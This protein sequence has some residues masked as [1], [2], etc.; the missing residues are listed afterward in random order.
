MTKICG[1]RV[2]PKDDA[3]LVHGLNT[4]VVYSRFNEKVCAIFQRP[5]DIPTDFKLP[6]NQYANLN[7]T[8][9]EFSRD[10]KFVI[11]TLFRNIY[12][13]QIS[14]GNL[15]TTIQAPVGIVKELLVSQKRSQI[16]THIKGARD[17][18]VW[19]IDEAV[20]QVNMLDRL[21]GPITSVLVTADSSM[22][23]IKCKDSDE[24]GVIDMGNGIMLDLLTHDSRVHDF[25]IT[26]TGSHVLTTITTK[27]KD[28]SAKLWDISGRKIMKEFGNASGYCISPH[29]ASYVLYVSQKDNA[30]NAP[31][32]ITMLKFVGDACH[33]TTHPLALKYVLSKPFLT[34][35]DK[36]LVV[37]TAQDYVQS[38]AYY[39]TPTICVFSMEEDMKVSYFT[40]ESF[41][42]IS[43]DSIE[44]IK[45]CP[46]NPYTIAV[47]YKSKQLSN[48]IDDNDKPMASNGS[49]FMHG[50][51]ILDVCSGSE[52][53]ICEPFL[54]PNKVLD[55]HLV[56]ANDFSLCLDSNSN[57]FQIS[58][59]FYVGQVPNMGTKP[60]VLALDG[61]VVLYFKGTEIY[62]VRI[63][64]GQLIAKCNVHSQ[65]CY[66]TLCKDE[67]TI[68]A[69][70]EDG[71]IASY[72]LVD[73][74]YD[75]VEEVIKTLKSRK[76][77]EVENM[78][79][80]QSRT[81]D[82]IENGQIP[83]HS[84]PPSSRS[85]GP[86]DKVLLKKVKPVPKV[87][88]KSDT[89]MYTNQHSKSCSVM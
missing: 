31:Y 44:D 32:F 45:S 67:R 19:N 11:G 39:D 56:F 5:R 66:L 17:I 49:S 65:L 84:R 48:Y 47:I 70:C 82:R 78:D 30:Y 74:L 71:T 89:L 1:L 55:R 58:E 68:I 12:L 4:L 52:H 42:E 21:T 26:P 63:Q 46:N 50:L 80:R 57:L 83:P 7:F 60:Q 73:P 43:I 54:D 3:V 29:V 16:V 36:Y 79:G 8:Q 81:W 76:Y 34:A 51:I 20:N 75:N 72:I 77:T 41:Q 25:A 18:Q 28:A 59:G 24:I 27:K 15:V 69:G 22:C 40:P 23:F 38:R 64:D 13:W 10:G 37:L 9:A 2:S 85:C 33:E 86:K 88:P 61:R 87:R 14:T 35:N 62:A 6:K 53:L